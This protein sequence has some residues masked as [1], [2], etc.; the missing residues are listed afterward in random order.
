MTSTDRVWDWVKSLPKNLR[1]LA[2][3]SPNFRL[4]LAKV[5]ISDIIDASVFPDYISKLRYRLTIFT[6]NMLWLTSLT[7]STC[8]P[9]LPW[10]NP[11][12]PWTR[13]TYFDLC[14]KK[15]LHQRTVNPG[16]GKIWG[17]LVPQRW[18]PPFANPFPQSCHSL[19]VLA[20]RTP[21]TQPVTYLLNGL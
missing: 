12:L 4:F 10:T 15:A 17:T 20:H 18:L 3:D 7:N 16:F 13:V 5:R 6:T 8:D 9:R 19:S 11:K 21:P 2:P 1:L 14:I